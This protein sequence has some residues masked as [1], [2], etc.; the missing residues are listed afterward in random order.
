MLGQVFISY[1]LLL[2]LGCAMVRDTS[3]LILGQYFKL[4]RDVA[5]MWSQA[6][7]GIGILVFSLLYSQA[8]GSDI[9]AVSG[10]SR[11]FKCPE[12]APTKD[13]FSLLKANR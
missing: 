11:S 13:L 6:G 3:S 10:L 7:T 2:G 4:R 8:I 1:G 5:E 9:R 12:K